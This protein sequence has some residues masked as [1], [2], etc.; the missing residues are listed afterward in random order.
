MYAFV[1]HQSACEALRLLEGRAGRWPQKARLLPLRGS[2]VSNQRAFR[3]LCEQE[4]LARY[5][6]VSRPVHMLVPYQ[7]ARSRG[8]DARFHV[9]SRLI[10]AGAMLRL[11]PELFLSGPE[12]TVIQHCGNNAKLDALLD[13]FHETVQ[14]ERE[15]RALIGADEGGL[16]IDHPLE[17]ERIRSLVNAA[18]LA[19]EFAGTYRLGVGESEVRYHVAPLMT[20]DSLRAMAQ[21][22]GATSM[23]NRAL[24]AADL[25]FDRS[26]SPM[27]TAVAL[28][29]TLPLEFG[30]FGLPRPD[31]NAPVD[32]AEVRGKLSD[33]DE[34]TPDEL[35]RDRFVALEYDSVE[36][37]GQLGPSQLTKDA[38]RANVLTAMGYKVF[39][40]TPGLVESLQG[41][42]LL[43]QQLAHALG[44]VLV[45]PSEMEMVRRRKLFIALMPRAMDR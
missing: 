32:T 38:R 10:P 13:D 43:A 30:G 17:W 5:G 35:W 20:C 18:V 6:I 15:V 2:C 9:W 40:V 37:H 36:F 24:R 3:Q 22:T 4:E 41:M 45:E 33:S 31:L 29:L 8:K 25:A 14:G 28:M 42:K 12:L 7:S 34:V 21:T 23:E 1:S 39:R 11:S 27:E 44:V 26:A 16:V 19:C